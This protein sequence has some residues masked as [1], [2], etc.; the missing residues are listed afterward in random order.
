MRI[1]PPPSDSSPELM[2]AVAMPHCSAIVAMGRAE[3]SGARRV[4]TLLT[5]WSRRLALHSGAL[6]PWSVLITLALCHHAAAA[7]P[8]FRG[9]TVT[10][11]TPSTI[12][13][14]SGDIVSVSGSHRL[15]LL[16]RLLR[17]REI[18]AHCSLAWE[19]LS[20]ARLLRASPTR[21]EALW[22]CEAF[23]DFVTDA[24]SRMHASTGVSP[25]RAPY[26]VPTERGKVG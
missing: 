2:R 11:D 6:S 21:C 23:A 15:H 7:Q 17:C 13:D 16:S 20:S 14:G 8:S 24:A 18:D 5:V 1:A 4:I 25:L 22:G 3:K 12:R 26:V 9:G 19:L 10:R